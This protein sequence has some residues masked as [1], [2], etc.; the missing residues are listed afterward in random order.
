MSKR[1]NTKIFIA[2]AN[3]INS[4]LPKP[5]LEKPIA[6]TKFDAMPNEIDDPSLVFKM[7]FLD[8]D[9]T[10]ISAQIVNQ[11]NEFEAKMTALR[12]N[13]Q[14]AINTLTSQHRTTSQ[15]LKEHKD[16]IEE[17]Y[18]IALKSYTFDD[19]TGKLKKIVL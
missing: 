11:K 17:K 12:N 13:Y 10:R 5:E 8:S 1:K 19:E 15:R 3:C 14:T 4:S 9:C 2:E 18:N 7:A 16:Y 6:I